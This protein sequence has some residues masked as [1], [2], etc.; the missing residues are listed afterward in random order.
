MEQ[1]GLDLH[2]NDVRVFARGAVWTRPGGPQSDID[3]RQ[4]LE[5]ARDSGM[6]MLRVPGTAVYE[7]A[8]MHDLCDELGIML[9]QDATLANFDYPDT[10]DDFLQLLETESSH[11]LAELAG[12]PST[13]VFCGGSEVEQQAAML[14][15]DPAIARSRVTTE[16]LPRLLTESGSDAVW[17]P[18]SPCGGELPFRTNH[19]IAHYY[20]VGGYRR[21]F[22]DV[23]RADVRFASECL[24]LANVPADDALATMSGGGDAAALLASAAW[25]DG[26]PRDRGAHWDFEDVRDFYLELVHGCSAAELR[27]DEPQR[28]LDLSRQVSGDVMSEVFGE[29]RRGD[30]TCSGGLVLWLADV[31]PGAGWGVIDSN[32]RP[33]PALAALRRML[34]PVAVWMTDEG[35]NGID[36]HVA[37]DR[38]DA[39]TARLDVALF[40][41][42]GVQVGHSSTDLV[43]A[44]HG[45]WTAGVES[46]LGGFVD[47]SWAYRFGPPAQESV[48][49]TLSGSGATLG[50]AVRLVG[51]APK[52]ARS[53]EDLGLAASATSGDAGVTVHVT[54]RLL[55]H[56]VAVD[57]PGFV[58]GDS[59]F[60]VPP[61]GEHVVRLT[62]DSG[63]S[64]VGSL[65]MS[66][67]NLLGAVTI[68]VTDAAP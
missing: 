6:N 29:W 53:A 37:N 20:G 47:V 25:R 40:R 63:G 65:R 1:D 49:A 45:T 28:Y 33:K 42:D 68:P 24:A 43:V 9:W 23:R 48:V 7:T 26:V 38:P 22:T 14:G 39:L 34:S 10:D 3:L 56:G 64:A 15:L 31:V 66:A 67:T 36:L 54:S 59:G 8:E 30:S 4:V 44:P 11:V 62:R 32:G 52:A 58:A 57:A 13:A 2:V 17:V 21:Q 51:D 46:V 41:D 50:R 12:R 35:L 5:L 55:V 27:R 16:L 60:F 61:G 18:S 19:G